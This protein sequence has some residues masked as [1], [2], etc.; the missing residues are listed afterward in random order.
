MGGRLFI[1]STPIG[2]LKDITFRAVEVLESVDLVVAEDTRR[3]LK[4]LNHLGIK[5]EMLSYYKPVERKKVEA[6]I[7]ALKSGKDVALVSDAGT[8]LV[9]DPGYELVRRCID[10]GIEVI[11]VPGPSSVL[12]ALV[13]SGIEPLPFCFYGFLP[14]GG[15]RRRLLE[16]LKGRTETLVFFESPNRLLDTLRDMLEVLGDRR[17]CVAREITK[18]HEEFVRGSISEVISC[19]KGREVLGEVCLVVEGCRE[20][21][22]RED[23]VEAALRLRRS[24][25]SARDVAKAVSA[26]FGVSKREV[27]DLVKG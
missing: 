15:E 2:N 13:A 18:V 7:D 22:P 14:R 10:E 26:I 21:V 11:P 3:T 24:G 27:Y 12:A 19:L 6:V 8:P 4:L 20:S 1:V 23:W 17:C 5:K 16:S 9:S 25:F